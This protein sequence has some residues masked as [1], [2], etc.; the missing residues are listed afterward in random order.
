[1]FSNSFFDDDDDFFGGSGHSGFSSFSSSSFG[2]PT[3]SSFSSFSSSSFG[4]GMGG[5][6]FVSTS[7][8][9]EVINGKKTIVKE[10]RDGKG[11]T[12]VER[13]IIE[14]DG[15]RTQETIVNG[16][17]QSFITDTQSRSSERLRLED[18][19]RSHH[20]NSHQHSHHSGH[21]SS[22]HSSHHS[23]R[24]SGSNNTK[25]SGTRAPETDQ[26]SQFGGYHH[27]F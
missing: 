20:S 17:Q 23:T 24:R 21:H 7:Q 13:T 2:G 26:R 15:R 8:R 4:G 1:M 16:K 6:N 19:Q 10:T 11:N 25:T 18:Q 14:P 22:H 9:T 5:G 12:T 3:T 27:F